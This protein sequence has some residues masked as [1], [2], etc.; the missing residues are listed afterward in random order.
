VL[1]Y[2]KA[3]GLDRMS[4]QRLKSEQNLSKCGNV[5]TLLYPM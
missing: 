5:I 2:L 4:G 3:F 1:K